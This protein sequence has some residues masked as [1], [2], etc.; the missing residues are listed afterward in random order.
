MAMAIRYEDPTG[1]TA[2]STSR[3]APIALATYRYSVDILL[4]RGTMF[5]N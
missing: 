1:K 2:P 4:T 5:T 3:L